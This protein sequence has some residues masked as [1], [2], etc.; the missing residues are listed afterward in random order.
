MG[1]CGACMEKSNLYHD[2]DDNDIVNMDKITFS[3]PPDTIPTAVKEGLEDLDDA[4]GTDDLK[5]PKYMGVEFPVYFQSPHWIQYRG[6]F[7]L[8]VDPAY[9]TMPMKANWMAQYAPEL[10]ALGK[11]ILEKNLN[12]KIESH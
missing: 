6:T 8:A 1:P 5:K 2:R 12:I 9:V 4:V 11:K 3:E 10:M 7:M